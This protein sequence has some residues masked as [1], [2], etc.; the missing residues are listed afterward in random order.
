[1]AE[2]LNDAVYCRTCGYALERLHGA[3]GERWLHMRADRRD[4]APDPAPIDEIEVVHTLCDFC[5]TPDPAWVYPT[6]NVTTAEALID[7][8]TVRLGDYRD[9]HNAARVVSRSGEGSLH[10]NLGDWWSACVDCAPFLEKK[11]LMGLLGRV[12]ESLP[13]RYRRAS[14]I[15]ETRARIRQSYEPLFEGG[16]GERVANPYHPSVREGM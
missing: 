3:L 1:M 6:A 12:V 4:H 16:F 5:S 9:Q 13:G 11:D 14:R 7:L 8:E 10:R 15:A 2:A